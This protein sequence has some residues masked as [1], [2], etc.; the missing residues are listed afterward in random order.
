MI[1]P[2]PRKHPVT[3]AFFPRDYFTMNLPKLESQMIG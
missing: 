1:R 3:I 2:R